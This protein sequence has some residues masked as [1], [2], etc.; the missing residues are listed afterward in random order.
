MVRWQS[1]AGVQKYN[2][3]LLKTFGLNC[4]KDCFKIV[5]RILGKG[6]CHSVRKE[7]P[8]KKKNTGKIL[9]SMAKSGV[10]HE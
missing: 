7:V 5:T 4:T 9:L 2:R 8:F 6:K 1:L 10:L 3:R